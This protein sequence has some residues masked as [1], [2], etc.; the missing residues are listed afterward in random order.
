DF[1][2]VHLGHQQV[3]QRAVERAKQAGLPS[4]MMTFDPHPRLVL[5]Q[6]QYESCLTPLAIK[7]EVMESLGLDYAY[8]VEFHEQFS[9]LTPAQFVDEMLLPL[10]VRSVVVG[11]DFSFGYQGRGTPDTLAEMGHGQFAVEVVR[12]FQLHGEKVS[13]SKVR[14]HLLSGQI[15]KANELLG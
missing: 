1:D 6:T 4:A 12:P 10:G 8:V 7:L 3:I 15:E 14:E 2:G 13:S 11:F 5:G 9:R